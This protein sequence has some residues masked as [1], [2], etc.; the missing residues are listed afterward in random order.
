MTYGADPLASEAA[1][2]RTDPARLAELAGAYPHLHPLIAANPACYDGLRDWMQ[3]VAAQQA[4]P[5]QPI[6]AAGSSASDAARRQVFGAPVEQGLLERAYTPVVDEGEERRKR[7]RKRV[8]WTVLGIVLGL[9]VA[10]GAV[11]GVLYASGTVLGGR[12]PEQAAERF[13]LGL[14]NADPLGTLAAT[15]PSEAASLRAP[16]EQLLGLDLGPAGTGGDAAAELRAALSLRFEGPVYSVEDLGD[17][18]ALVEPDGGTALLDGDPGALADVLTRLAEPALR[19][20][21]DVPLP[22]TAEAETE[23]EADDGQDA[24]AQEAPDEDQAPTGEPADP[25]AAVDAYREAAEQRLA[26]HLPAEIDLSGEEA[27]AFAVVVV[28]EGGGWYASPLLTAAE[29]AYRDL[30]DEA[31]PRGEVRAAADL[32]RYDTPL[33]AAEGLAAGI[34]GAVQGE[35]LAGAAAAMPLTERR[36]VEIYGEALIVPRL[37]ADAVVE[38]VELQLSAADAEPGELA[39]I[40]GAVELLLDGRPLEVTASCSTLEESENES[41]ERCLADSALLAGLGAEEWQLVAVSED[42]GW[43]VGGL[44]SL[45]GALSI[46]VERYAQLVAAGEVH[47]LVDTEPGADQAAPEE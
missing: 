18:I 46:A 36:L 1:D 25:D 33:L 11:F 26:E 8:L 43:R 23:A 30:G 40:G 20:G 29:L 13:A 28:E 21:L 2:P 12:S 19:A 24:E 22:P 17:G 39:G 37:P 34:V 4:S 32:P 3:Q 45:G 16:V 27:D 9:A 47:R 7:T 14:G 15:A 5:A 35:G 41:V 44:A 31:P 6:A 42:G 10:A 38:L